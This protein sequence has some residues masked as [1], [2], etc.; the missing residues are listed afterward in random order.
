VQSETDLQDLPDA[1]EGWTASRRPE[2]VGTDAWGREPR[3]AAAS[4]RAGSGD[5]GRV[6][7]LRLL[8]R[9]PGQFHVWRSPQFGLALS[10]AWT[11]VREEQTMGAAAS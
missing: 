8:L 9:S 6:A 2:A 5:G 7:A 3:R 11:V 1:C 4:A 10:S